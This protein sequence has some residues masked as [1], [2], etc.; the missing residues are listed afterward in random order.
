ML[1]KR[2]NFR[3]DLNFQAFELV[4]RKNAYEEE[5]AKGEVQVRE[6]IIL[7]KINNL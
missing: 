7:G 2:S 4:G 1:G 6:S 3:V 5:G